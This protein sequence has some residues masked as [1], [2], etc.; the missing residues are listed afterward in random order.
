[1]R[2][3]LDIL[4]ILVY[5]VAL[6]ILWIC[7]IGA[8]AYEFREPV[9]RYRALRRRHAELTR[10]VRDSEQELQR[11]MHRIDRLRR[12]PEELAREA[13]MLGLVGEG[14]VLYIIEPTAEGQ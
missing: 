12:D 1:M 4:W 7:V 9:L 5:R 10:Q 8:V 3:R 2:Q 6:V 14:E 11:L 13:R